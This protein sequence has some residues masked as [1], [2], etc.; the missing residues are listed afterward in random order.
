MCVCDAIELMVLGS[1]WKFIDHSTT[2]NH[3]GKL[4]KFNLFIFY[5]IIHMAGMWSLNQ[6][7]FKL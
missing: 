7:L 2:E 5:I 1:Y 3:D 4:V 6:I